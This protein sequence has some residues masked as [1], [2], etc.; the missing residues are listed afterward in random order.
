MSTPLGNGQDSPGKGLGVIRTSVKIKKPPDDDDLDLED[1]DSLFDAAEKR[2]KKNSMEQQQ[3]KAADETS[4]KLVKLKVPERGPIP[5]I[6]PYVCEETTESRPQRAQ[7]G[8]QAPQSQQSPRGQV[9]DASSLAS[10][11][12]PQDVPPPFAPMPIHVSLSQD[13][14]A[15]LDIPPPRPRRAS[16]PK[17]RDSQQA[18]EQHVPQYDVQNMSREEIQKILLEDPRQV[19]PLPISIPSTQ[20]QNVPSRMSHRSILYQP[21]KTLMKERLEKWKTQHDQRLKTHDEYHNPTFAPVSDDYSP[22]PYDVM[23]VPGCNELIEAFRAL[24][25]QWDIQNDDK[26]RETIA[27]RLSDGPQLRDR[28]LKEFNGLTVT[29]DD[30]VDIFLEWRQITV[31][32]TIEALIELGGIYQDADL[33][34]PMEN[35]IIET[36]TMLR[37]I[38]ASAAA[39]FFTLVS[40]LSFPNSTAVELSSQELRRCFIFEFYTCRYYINRRYSDNSLFSYI[41]AKFGK[42]IIGEI[43]RCV[44]NRLSLYTDI[45]LGPAMEPLCHAYGRKRVLVS[46]SNIYYEFSEVFDFI[47]ETSIEIASAW[48]IVMVVANVQDAADDGKQYAQM[49]LLFTLCFVKAPFMHKEVIDNDLL[50]RN[51]ELKDRSRGDREECPLDYIW[52]RCE[53]ETFTIGNLASILYFAFTGNVIHNILQEKGEK[54]KWIVVVSTFMD[55]LGDM[56]R[57]SVIF[58]ESI[59]DNMSSRFLLDNASARVLITFFIHG[60]AFHFASKFLSWIR[61][62]GVEEDG[63]DYHFFIQDMKDEFVSTIHG[64]MDALG[65]EWRGNIP[66]PLLYEARPNTIAHFDERMLLLYMKYACRIIRRIN[67]VYPIVEYAIYDRRRELLGNLRLMEF[68]PPIAWTKFQNSTDD[69]KKFYGVRYEIEPYDGPLQEIDQGIKFIVNALVKSASFIMFGLIKNKYSLVLDEYTMDVYMR[70]VYHRFFEVP[71]WEPPVR[72]SDAIHAS[73]LVRYA[74]DYAHQVVEKECEISMLKFK[75]SIPMVSLNKDMEIEILKQPILIEGP[76]DLSQKGRDTVLMMTTDK[77]YEKVQN[78][79]L[80]ARLEAQRKAREPKFEVSKE[81]P[82]PVKVL[83]KSEQ[84]QPSQPPEITPE[85]VVHHNQ[86]SDRRGNHRDDRRGN[87]HPRGRGNHRDDSRDDRRGSGRGRAPRNNPSPRVTLAHSQMHPEHFI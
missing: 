73:T 74:F 49:N 33:F 29:Q 22:D 43:Y 81:K 18:Q 65:F 68:L 83:Q 15:S 30:V 7:Q 58:I 47:A 26:Y 25:Y 16:R 40:K 8:R 76:A 13:Q 55:G 5:G 28:R 6:K 34:V 35:S 84:T 27:D 71:E 86:Q 2:G 87:P 75:D 17:Q 82:P 60:M 64:L 37:R 63:S 56:V 48:L 77:R 78:E 62:S 61:S 70:K 41:I 85:R 79:L 39:P 66:S 21:N 80:E 23:Y 31:R 10:S 4:R 54:P 14:D 53:K 69:V 52:M 9:Q 36:G 19:I 1:I 11:D 44:S 42:D 45:E 32:P 72:T 3:R 67:D 38:V 50:I 51:L 59:L 12:V 24:S 57:K 46:I 20:E